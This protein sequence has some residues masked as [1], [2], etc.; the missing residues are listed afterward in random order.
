MSPTT[1][2]GGPLMAALP[3]I[4]AAVGLALTAAGAA[5]TNRLMT[6]QAQTESLSRQNAVLA[7]QQRGIAQT[8]QR[9]LL[10]DRLPVLDG[11]EVAARHEAGAQGAEIGGDWYEVVAV[12]ADRLLLIVGDVSGRG[13][14]AAAT[15]ASL[16][17]SAR[18]LR[19]RRARTER[20]PHQAE[21]VARRVARRTFRD[22]PL[23]HHRHPDR[24]DPARQRRAPEPRHR[25]RPRRP[26]RRPPARRARRTRPRRG[27]RHTSPSD[28]AR[29]A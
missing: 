21:P 12:D 23:R 16:R 29:P 9:S 8:L 4:I 18:G 13:L 27:V 5:A 7:D 11:I 28:R 22:R 1:S 14:P 2:L 25:R 10:P 26:P 3:W 6:R 20:D 15:M 17:F 19:V 24:R